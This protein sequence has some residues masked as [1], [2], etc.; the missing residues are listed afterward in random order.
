MYHYN[1]ISMIP[2]IYI[3]ELFLRD[4][5]QSLSKSYSVSERY[6]MFTLLNNC[7]LKGIE[8]GST[9]HPKIV[10]QM[11]G[12]YELWNLI[13][14]NLKQDTTYTMLTPSIHHLDKVLLS[15]IT[16]IGL[17]VSLSDD[18]AYKNMRMTSRQTFDQAKQMIDK[19]PNGV[20]IRIYLSYAF[21]TQLETL[22]KITRYTKELTSIAL[23]RNYSK[24]RFDIVLADTVGNCDVETIQTVL[25]AIEDKEFIGVHLHVK[26]EFERLLDILLENKI[27]KFDSSLLGIGGCPYAEELIG[28]VSTLPLVKYLHKKGYHT[29]VNVEVLEKASQEININR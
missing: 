24:N 25:D 22:E 2:D 15:D 19:I 26:A 1:N 16:S 10:P 21:D 17:V 7:G 9:T 6:E 20:H 11:E 18:F 14:H 23:A 12:S 5:L 13:K 28:N 8:F 4:G 29:G 27:Y 3:Y